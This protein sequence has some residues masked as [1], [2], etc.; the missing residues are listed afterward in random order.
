MIKLEC[1]RCGHKLDYACPALEWETVNS[2][3][4]QQGDE[5]FLSA[6]HAFKCANCGNEML[7]DFSCSEYMPGEWNQGETVVVSGAKTIEDDCEFKPPH[8]N[9]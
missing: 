5:V 2:T 6:Q 4:R 8:Q 1:K 9:R 3:E 7:V